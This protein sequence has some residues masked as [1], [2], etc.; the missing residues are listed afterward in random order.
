MLLLLFEGL[1]LLLFEGLL[2]FTLLLLL[3]LLLLFEGLYSVVAGGTSRRTSEDE[4]DVVDVA[5]DVSIVR[6]GK[7]AAR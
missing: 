4:L 1:L 2:L 6:D 7:K 3:L 5:D